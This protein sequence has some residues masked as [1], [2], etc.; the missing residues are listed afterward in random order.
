M[1]KE[2]KM[3]DISFD[4]K[5]VAHIDSKHGV[6]TIQAQVLYHFATRIEGNA[7]E[8]GSYL[9]RSSVVIASGLKFNGRK[10]I[11]FAIDPWEMLPM[12][13]TTL[14]GFIANVRASECGDIIRPVHGF[15]QK[16]L[17]EKPDYIFN[18][19]IGML[20][21]DGDHSYE[22]IK[23]DLGWIPFVS[24]DGIIAFHDYGSVKIPG[25][26]KAIDEYLRENNDKM[27]LIAFI[28]SLIIFK[29]L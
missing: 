4:F 2:Y 18:K 10:G 8:I 17:E 11:L 29:K 5:R 23:K 6:S 3:K 21:I 28:E 13:K 15:A 26:T 14:K 9:G 1:L 19:P 27:K 22:E 12:L 25:P 7:I 24:K 16:V 20:F